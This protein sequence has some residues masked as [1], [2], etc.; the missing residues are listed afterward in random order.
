MRTLGRAARHL[1]ATGT[2]LPDVFLPL[3]SR[4]I[5]FR[6]GTVNFIAGTPG[7]MKTGLALYLV[8]RWG[9]PTL[10][11]S[12]D[13]EPFEMVERLA[14]MAT[15]DPVTKV[16]SDYSAYS[17]A[18]STLPIRM[19]FEDSPTYE[20]LFNEVTAY[21]EVY[22]EAPEVIVIDNIMN[23][24]GESEDEWGA[25]RDHARV[26][27][28]LCR[29]TGAT[30]L[31]LAHMGEDVKDSSARPA[32]RT[33]LQGKI[34]QLPKMILSLAFDSTEKELK[35]CA[36]KNRFGPADPSGSDFAVLPATPENNRF[37]NSRADYLAGRCA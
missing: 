5:R 3:S 35:V 34:S 22:G 31:V 1:E 13:S 23:L 32:P 37:Y 28:K 29:V 26:I 10:Y 2:F 9:R 4:G 25:H 33:K 19:T 20:D 36:V 15:G 21:V 6:T 11:F 17:E 12:A 16:R 30:V 7:S 27:H 14:S 24:T 18:L 8:G